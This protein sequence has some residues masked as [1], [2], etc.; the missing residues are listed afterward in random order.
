M[1][2][3]KISGT[4]NESAYKPVKIFERNTSRKACRGMIR[5]RLHSGDSTPSY[6]LYDRSRTAMVILC[7][8]PDRK[9]GASFIIE[10]VSAI[11]ALPHGRASDTISPFSIA[12]RKMSS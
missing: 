1:S 4:L 9:G 7:Q 5:K 11:V 2:T 12:F 3:A 10:I 6:R 8:K